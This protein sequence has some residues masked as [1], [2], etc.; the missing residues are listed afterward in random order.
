M[1]LHKA[2]IKNYF[3]IVYVS[4]TMLSHTFSFAAQHNLR[5]VIN[6][7]GSSPYIYYDI[8]HARYRGVVVDF[9]NSFHEA[10]KFNVEYIDSSRSRNEHFVYTEQADLFFGSSVWVSNP[11]HFIYSDPLM[12]HTSFLYSKSKFKEPFVFD[13]YKPA[14]ICTRRGFSY[15]NLQPDFETQKLTRVDS[16]SQT[17]MALMLGKGRCDFAYMSQENAWAIMSGPEF[18]EYTFYQSPKAI[19]FVNLEFVMGKRLIREKAKINEQIAIFV[20]SG[21]LNISIRKHLKPSIF[22]KLTCEK[23]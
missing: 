5:F 9:F 7:P 6:S 13:S 3:L 19:S 2:A 4:L 23:K 22:P 20:N 21:A 15:P 18:C 10:D 17:T 11:N 12:P 8:E 16:I 1:K 14:S